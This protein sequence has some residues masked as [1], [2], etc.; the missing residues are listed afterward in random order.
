MKTSY[1]ANLEMAN[2]MWRMGINS[3][4]SVRDKLTRLYEIEDFVT[5]KSGV[6]VV[7]IVNA[8]FMVTDDHIFGLPNYD[9]IER[10]LKWYESQSLNVHDIPGSTPTIWISVAD[11]DGRINSN[12]GWMIYSEENGKQ[13]DNVVKE[14]IQNPFS[15]RAEM[16]YTRPSMHRD[17]CAG[18]MNDFCCTETVQYLLRDN[19]LETIVKMRSNDA[20]AGFRND[21]AWQKHVQ[22]KVLTELNNR[23]NSYELGNIYWN[24]GSLHVYSRQFYL[25]E[26]YLM[27]GETHI[28]KEDFAKIYPESKLL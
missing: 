12:Y 14:L 4:K 11:S 22:S 2:N 17:Y 16:I 13:F 21:Y 28:S 1:H 25:L 27:T 5:D 3:I 10:E 15:R 23:G 26:H 8:A 20:W 18:G 7:E 6:K 24:V 19:M 9:Y